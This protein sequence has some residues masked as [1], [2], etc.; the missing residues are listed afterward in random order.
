MVAAPPGSLL[1]RAFTFRPGIRFDRNR[2]PP[3]MATQ[4]NFMFMWVGSRVNNPYLFTLGRLP[5]L[6]IQ[7]TSYLTNGIVCSTFS[8][9]L[10]SHRQAALGISRY[11]Q[12]TFRDTEGK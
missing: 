1:R 4:L 7:L 3:L 8:G 2:A 11:V 9:A 12:K 10:N 5:S 6:H